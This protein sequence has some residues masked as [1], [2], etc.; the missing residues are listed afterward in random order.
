MVPK[1]VATTPAVAL[2]RALLSERGGG[3]VTP[4]YC[5]NFHFGSRGGGGAAPPPNFFLW[6]NL[7]LL[8]LWRT[9]NRVLW[10]FH[11]HHFFP[12]L[13]ISQR[14]LSNPPP[15]PPVGLPGAVVFSM[16]ARVE[17]GL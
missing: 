7:F 9:Y 8:R 4:G 12:V 10:S 11:S 1:A 3:A 2:T 15:P 13:Q 16:T 6:A 17:G 14:P 5:F